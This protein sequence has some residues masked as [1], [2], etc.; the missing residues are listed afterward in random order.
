MQSV[1]TSLR[2]PMVWGLVTV[3]L[4]MIVTLVVGWVYISPPHRQLVTFYTDDAASVR[5]G[6]SVRVAGIDVGTVK[7]ISIEPQQVRVQLSVKDNVFIGDQTQVEV[8]MLTVVGGYFV[9]L[10]PLGE[11]ALGRNTIP[12]DRVTMP[13]SLIRTLSDATKITEQVAARPFNESLNQLQQG[14]TGSNT[15]ILAKLLQAGNAV[16]EVMERQRGQLTSILNMSNEYIEQLNGNRELLEHM[17]SRVAILEETLVLYGKGFGATTEGL[18]EITQRLA[19]VGPWYMSHRQDFLD[20]VRGIL[21]EFQTIAD[22]N[23]VVVRVLR[24]VRQRMQSTLD[25]QNAGTPPQLLAT[26]LCFPT[27]GS[28]C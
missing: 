7:N 19:P 18:G 20:R 22:R 5:G 8:R 25:A 13:Y 16:S 4:T 24:R 1:T 10:V 14:L 17:I 3:A 11:R 21:G 12:M 9:T 6:D 15:E 23:G 2:S 28:R 26:D 27:E